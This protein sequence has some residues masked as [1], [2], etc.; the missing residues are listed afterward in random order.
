MS[1]PNQKP[2]DAGQEPEKK[3][4]SAASLDSIITSA[5]NAVQSRHSTATHGTT[6]T[7]ISYDGATPPGGGGSVGTGFASGQ[8]STGADTNTPPNA[9]E[10]PAKPM[11]EQPADQDNEREDTKPDTLGTP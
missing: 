7:N 2:T 6:G 10:T 9:G 1:Q 11:K 8:E 3:H 4:S 5:T